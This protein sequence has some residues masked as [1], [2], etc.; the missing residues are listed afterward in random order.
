[1]IKIFFWNSALMAQK[2]EE[3]NSL[4]FIQERTLIK[5]H[6]ERPI[7]RMKTTFCEEKIYFNN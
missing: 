1:M 6:T 7:D 3:H 5:I 4:K 2:C